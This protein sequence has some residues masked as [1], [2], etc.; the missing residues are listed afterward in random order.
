MPSKVFIQEDISQQMSLPVN[1]LV[2]APPGTKVG[3]AI[4]S[5]ALGKKKNG[6]EINKKDLSIMAFNY[7]RH[8]QH[9][10]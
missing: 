10:L 4:V 2:P 5:L 8:T 9:K 3:A 6:Q 7:L 1:T